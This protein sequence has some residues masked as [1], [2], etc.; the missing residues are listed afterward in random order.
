MKNKIKTNDKMDEV[1]NENTNETMDEWTN[2][3]NKCKSE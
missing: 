2:D 3:K 1:R